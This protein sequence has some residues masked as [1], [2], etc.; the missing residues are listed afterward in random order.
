MATVTL[1]IRDLNDGSLTVEIKTDPPGLD[2]GAQSQAYN[3]ATFLISQLDEICDDI[4]H[5]PDKETLS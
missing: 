4:E 5:V 1:I 3:V 2:S